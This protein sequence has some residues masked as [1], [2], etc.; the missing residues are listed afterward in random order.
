MGAAAV[1]QLRHSMVWKFGV[2]VGSALSR[3]DSGME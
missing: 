1:V 3:F 2:W